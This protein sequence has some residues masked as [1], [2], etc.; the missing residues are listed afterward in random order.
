MKKL[1][2]TALFL[3]LGTNTA[4]ANCPSGI[5]AVEINATTG[6]ITYRDAPPQ[7]DISEPVKPALVIP[8]HTLN[9]PTLNGN[10]GSSG[11]PEQ[12]AQAVQTLVPEPLT[13]ASCVNNCTKVEINVATGAKTILSYTETELKQLTKDKVEQSQK[14]AEL[15][16]DAYQAL[17]N[18]TAWEQIDIYSSEKKTATI[19]NEEFIPEWWADWIISL[20]QFFKNWFWW[21][22]S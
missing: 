14:Q 15:A 22:A 10:W 2:I 4:V 8:T 6:A 20:N 19:Q 3:V 16:K 21:W 11:T 17:P 12:I 18:I 7:I 9:V 1:L 5:C 13:I